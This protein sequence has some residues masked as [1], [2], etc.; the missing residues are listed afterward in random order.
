MQKQKPYTHLIWDFNGTILDDIRLGIDCV[1]EMLAPRGLPVIPDED[2]YREIFGFPIDDYYRRLGFDFEKED[3]DTVL[4]PE[5]VAKYLAG[6]GNCTV[7][8]GVTETIQAV[9]ALGIP[10]VVLSASKVQQLTGQLERLGLLGEFEEV[11]GLDNIHARSKK[12]QALE[13]M[14]A[15]PDARPLFVGDTEHDADVA[16]AVGADCLLYTG[17]HQSQKR[18]QACGKPLIT[19]IRRLI[20]YLE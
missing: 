18:L 4:A 8:P 14:A 10:Q 11:I 12:A 6:E 7:M 9:K 16:D 15:H 2:T 17:G 13:W 1:N 19:D 5:W 20:A 3:Y